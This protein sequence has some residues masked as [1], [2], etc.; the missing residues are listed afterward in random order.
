[1]HHV[2]PDWFYRIAYT[3]MFLAGSKLLWD[4]LR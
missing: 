3:G 1:V 4:G 2:R